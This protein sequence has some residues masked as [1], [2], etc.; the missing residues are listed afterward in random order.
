MKTLNIYNKCPTCKSNNIKYIVKKN[1]PKDNLVDE[2]INTHKYNCFFPYHVCKSCSLYYVKEYFEEKYLSFLYNKLENNVF[3]GS[4]KAHTKTQ[5]DYFRILS[6]KVV[7]N[8][9][10]VLEFGPDIG[11]LSKMILKNMHHKIII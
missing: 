1:V 6:K 8:L 10:N 5:E 9:S 4:M 7:G 2:W 11:I 3:S